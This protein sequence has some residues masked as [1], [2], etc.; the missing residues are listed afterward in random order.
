MGWRIAQREKGA[1]LFHIVLI[2]PRPEADVAAVERLDQFL[3][4]LPRLIPGITDYHWGAN[5]SPEGMGRG[6]E[7]GFLMTFENAAARDAYLPH[8]EHRKVG[9]F[10][11]AVAQE[12]LVFDIEA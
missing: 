4:A 11:D 5:V 6:Y 3:C 2:K 12:V 9:P 10:M 1:V 7:L 8:P